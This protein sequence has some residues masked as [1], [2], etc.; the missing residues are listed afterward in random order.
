MI[1]C[2]TDE[3]GMIILKH[4]LEECVVNM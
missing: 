2:K 4:I 1:T 3:Y